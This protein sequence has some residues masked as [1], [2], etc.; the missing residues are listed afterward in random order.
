MLSFEEQA[1]DCRRQALS[2]VGHP[3]ASLL[4]RVAREFD[5]LAAESR[6]RAAERARSSLAPVREITTRVVR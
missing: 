1:E 6:Y 2:Y 5:R 3:E 4:I